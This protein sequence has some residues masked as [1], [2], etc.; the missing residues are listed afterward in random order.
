LVIRK[1]LASSAYA[2]QGTL[3]TMIDRLEK[4]LPLTDALN[5]S[6]I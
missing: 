5:Q 3:A 2:I 1:I 4:K 6:M